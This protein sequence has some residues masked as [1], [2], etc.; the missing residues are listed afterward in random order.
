M[1]T[2]LEKEIQE[3]EAH[4][5]CEDE[6]VGSRAPL[7]NALLMALAVIS[8]LI[9][10]WLFYRLA[11]AEA[12]LEPLPWA[13][14]IGIHVG[15][16]AFMSL[17]AYR[18]IKQGCGKGIYILLI[19]ST[20]FLG[21]I[22]AMG[23][24]ITMVLYWEYAR[25]TTSF[26]EWYEALF[27]EEEVSEARTLANKLEASGTGGEGSLTPFNDILN[28]GSQRQK[29]SMIALISRNFKPAFAPVLNRA[30]NDPDNSIRVQA[31][32]AATFVENGF[33]KQAMALEEQLKE[34][35]EN[36]EILLA[37]ASHYDDYAYT[38][39][40]DFEREQQNRDKAIELYQLY[41][42]EDK[43][44]TRVHNALGR[45]LLK[46]ERFEE[47]R[48]FLE[49]LLQEGH[50]PKSLYLWYM[51]CLFHLQDYDALG[52]AADQLV[53]KYGDMAFPAH[54]METVLFWH[55][56]RDN[57]QPSPP[58]SSVPAEGQA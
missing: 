39:L 30:L 54:I 50:A 8:S 56:R 47:A 21:F 9:E 3:R 40:L 43:D 58:L 2:A 53:E 27:P 46:N 10:L 26:D 12:N 34:A 13:E 14:V 33:L 37:L 4:Q 45:N 36:A 6:S 42:L 29:Q 28:H 7:H 57:G 24:A 44:N 22:G 18:P 25:H 31:A 48:T 16:V 35:P 19:G 49:H 41:L 1:S 32:T 20:L 17:L 51:E 52:E 23:S 55:H 15:W 38:G 5:Q 11:M